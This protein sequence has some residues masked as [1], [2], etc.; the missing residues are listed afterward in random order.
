MSVVSVDRAHDDDRLCGPPPPLTTRRDGMSPK[1]RTASS[2]KPVNGPRLP[3]YRR[4]GERA[5]TTSGSPP[6]LPKNGS[7]YQPWRVTCHLGQAGN[8]NHQYFIS[9]ALGPWRVACHVVR[10]R[11]Q[12]EPLTGTAY[13]ASP[14][15]AA[16]PSRRIEPWGALAGRTPAAS[17]FLTS[18]RS[19]SLHQ[20]ASP[21]LVRPVVS[22]GLIMRLLYSTCTT[23]GERRRCNPV[24]PD[25]PCGRPLR[26][27]IV[28]PP[29]ANGQRPTAN[30]QQPTG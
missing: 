27:E 17:A 13:A 22:L 28:Q 25:W 20:P 12:A 7:I 26:R 6:P 11:R 23:S 15:P 14:P 18:Q 21:N 30:S 29:A 4:L 3:V 19:S 2:I 1:T 16:R 10:G 5:E 24:D 8:H 9:L